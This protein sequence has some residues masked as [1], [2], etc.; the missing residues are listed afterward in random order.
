MYLAIGGVLLAGIIL[1]FGLQHGGQSQTVTY[2][3]QTRDFTIS[4]IATLTN[5]QTAVVPSYA[6]G[7]KKFGEV[8]S[9]DPNILV[10]YQ[11]DTVNLTIND[12]QP[13]DPHTF[14]MSAPYD[15]V[16]ATVG[17]NSQ[18]IVTFKATHV[19]T[20]KFYCTVPGHLP[21]MYG[22]LVVLPASM[23]GGYASQ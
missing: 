10:V 11:G 23:G 6:E 9:F 17:P 3:P 13:D 15:Q 2:V 7:V 21:A 8:Y 22:Q 18:Q 12:M 1:Y 4:T 19:G 14:T 16:N 20:F 5:E